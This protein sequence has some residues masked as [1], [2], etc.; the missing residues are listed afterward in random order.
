MCKEGIDI[1]RKRRHA[2][3]CQRGAGRDQRYVPLV[4]YKHK[5]WLVRDKIAVCSVVVDTVCAGRGS[6]PCQQTPRQD[7]FRRPC[8]RRG[9]AAASYTSQA[10]RQW[11]LP[12]RTTENQAPRPWWRPHA[13]RGTAAWALISA[14]PR[15]EGQLQTGPRAKVTGKGHGQGHGL[16]PLLLTGQTRRQPRV[17]G[18]A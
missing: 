12:R 2:H 6:G 4:G 8:D 7:G 5:S 14:A 17:P 15:A 18:W 1:G 9:S 11:P 3:T 13:V 10:R 16:V